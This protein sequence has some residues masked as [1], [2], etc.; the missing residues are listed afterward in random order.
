MSA[1]NELRKKSD[2]FQSPRLNSFE[3]TH[4]YDTGPAALFSFTISPSGNRS[5]HVDPIIHEKLS[6]VGSSYLHIE[7]NST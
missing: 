2:A 7:N 4:I 1:A 3:N 5:I 6:N